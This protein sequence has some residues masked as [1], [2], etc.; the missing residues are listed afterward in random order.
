MLTESAE[1]D[2]DRNKSFISEAWWVADKIA[3]WV[4]ALATQPDG[5]GPSQSQHCVRRGPTPEAM[6]STRMLGTCAHTYIMH[7][8]TYKIQLKVKQYHK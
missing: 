8:Q 4:K 7:M 3:P 6:T 5:W 1:F 2:K